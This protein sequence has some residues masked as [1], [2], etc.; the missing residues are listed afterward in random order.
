MGEVTTVNAVGVK[1]SMWTLEG[2]LGNASGNASDM[3]S[4]LF[5]IDTGA[6]VN[7]IPFSLVKGK[8]WGPL[9]PPGIKLLGAAETKLATKGVVTLSLSYRDRVITDKFYV[10]D[11]LKTPLLGITG[12]NKLDIVQRIGEMTP[13]KKSEKTRWTQKFPKMFSGLG[14]MNTTY[15]I[16]LKENAEPF[17][18][19][20]PRRVP[21]PLLD[22]VKTELKKLE[23]E[24][25]KTKNIY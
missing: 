8:R 17:S 4:V 21:L 15:E 20:S 3:T 12:I 6:S 13:S 2:S 16:K 25:E 23:N 24:N 14:T 22:S 5:K 9:Q 11:N 10:V 19:S 1:S 18:V 7:C